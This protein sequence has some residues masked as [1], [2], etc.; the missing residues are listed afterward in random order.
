MAPFLP[1][2]RGYQPAWLRFDV[3]AGL[4][5]WAV[6]VPESLAY[7][8]IAGV[9]PVVGLYA[10]IPALVLYA[11]FGTSRVVVVATM[12]ATAALSASIVGMYATA[13]GDDFIAIT[14]GLAI[15]TGIL[16]I[17]AGLARMGFLAS[18]ISQ[19]VLKGFVVGLALT[20]IA[21]QLPALFGV[22]KESGN[23]FEE[24]A[25]LFQ[26][27]PETDGATLAVGAA[28]LVVV[29]GCRRWLPLLPGS[30]LAVLLGIAATAVLGLEDKGVEVVGTITAGLPTVGVPDGL[31]FED[32]L[33]LAGAATG[34]LLLGFVEGLGPAKSYAAR[35]GYDIDPNRELIGLGAANLGAGLTSGMVV[36]GSL[37]KSAVNANS[38]ARSQVSNLTVA[39]LVVI[40]LLFLT[41]I[42]ETLPEAT[43]AAVVIAAV[44]ELVDVPALVRLYRVWTGQPGP[45]LR[46]GGSRRLHRGP[47]RTHRGP[48]VR[49]P[50]RPVHRHR[51]VRP[52]SGVPVIATRG[53]HPCQDRDARD[54]AGRVGRCGATPRPAHAR[55]RDRCA[56]RV[57]DLL[58]QR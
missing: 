33:A 51:R 52:P 45:H 8:T 21:G 24:I 10:A 13:G 42:F 30:L 35:D 12:S 6:L 47:R 56:G 19:P 48:R 57:R 32:Y 41:G 38:G 49:H 15:V 3:L 9:P 5:V 16:G 11:V 31:G 27:L 1:S 22:P 55:R 20:I 50:S 14:A 40:T 46:L 36:N 39:A 37:S 23:F 54:R 53:S 44:I 26:N 7:A 34:V 18:F 2:L 17:A 25:G 43:L 4:S 29:L 28:S 58:R